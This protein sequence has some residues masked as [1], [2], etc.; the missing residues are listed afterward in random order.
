MPF[1]GY[2]G[3]S[4]NAFYMKIKNGILLCV[5]LLNTASIYSQRNADAGHFT[6][7]GH[8]KGHVTA[9]VYIRYS[10]ATGE[11]R[12]DS[13]PLKDGH[14]RLKGFIPEPTIAFLTIVKKSLPDEDV[15]TMKAD[16]KNATL[17][18]L[19]PKTIHALL[20]S[21]DFNHAQFAGSSSQDQFGAFNAQMEGS[22]DE[23][24]ADHLRHFLEQHPA[25]YVSAYLISR[26]HFTFDTLVS[27][28]NR[29]TTKIKQ[30]AYGKAIEDNIRKKELVTAGK[31]APAF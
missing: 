11:Y 15:T 19:E 3:Q 5:L 23:T 20:D 8:V 28:Y 2:C 7:E 21:G 27:Y 4:I 12:I 9:S 30:S 24:A 13:C 17:F 26:H 22:T 16:G 31:Q 18:F 6:L 25:S 1:A 14:F 29:L 10:G